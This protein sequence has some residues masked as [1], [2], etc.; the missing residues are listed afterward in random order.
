MT[1]RVFISA[2]H[3]LSLIYFLQSEVISTLLHAGVEVV[4]FTDDEARPAIEE[5]F[6]RPGIIFEGLRLNEC[7]RYFQT[8]DPFIQRSLQM[9]RWVGGSKRIN[10]TA[11]EGNYQLL[12]GG[13]TGTGRF[14]L[15]LLRIM[16]WLMRRSSLLRRL[17]VRIQQH[18][19]PKIYKDLFEK[20]QPDLVVART[21]G[22]RM[23]RYLLR[24]AAA[25]GVR[26]VATIVGWD[27]PSS[28]SLKGAPV[29]YITCWSELQ[30]EEL[31]L[32]SD[33]DPKRVN[34]SG[35]PSYDGYFLRSWLIPRD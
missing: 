8:V 15:P 10:V 24:E 35:I 13:F 29:D 1:S 21:P 30:K 16:I 25:R 18:Y 33:W 7:E 5:R 32:G 2:D 20:Y 14:A 34:I 6:H 4:L 12:A 17:V 23:D 3:G 19:N 31:V 26:T 28:Y 22:W 27:N 11:M 9:L